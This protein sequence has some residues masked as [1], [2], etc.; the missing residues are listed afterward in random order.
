MS[1]GWSLGSPALG[2]HGRRDRSR[3]SAILASFQ[4]TWSRGSPNASVRPCRTPSVRVVD[5]PVQLALIGRFVVRRRRR[6][7]A[8]AGSGRPGSTAPR[9]RHGPPLPLAESALSVVDRRRA[10]YLQRSGQ[11]AAQHVG[12]LREQRLAPGVAQPGRAVGRRQGDVDHKIGDRNQHHAAQRR[13]RSTPGSGRSAVSALHCTKRAV[14]PVRMVKPISDT[15]N[16]PAPAIRSASSGVVTNFATIAV[17]IMEPVER[18]QRGADPGD[19]RQ[20][21]A[22]K[23]A[24]KREQRRQQDDGENARGRPGSRGDPDPLATQRRALWR[25]ARDEI[26]QTGRSRRSRARPRAACGRSARRHPGPGKAELR[27]FLEP[28][29]AVADR[30]D[31]ARQRRSRRRR[32]CRPA[33]ASR[34]APRAMPRRPPGRPPAR[35]CASRRRR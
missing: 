9:S 22:H 12:A 18:D 34:S 7:A 2:K 26:A 35:R 14:D 13:R 8:W 21:L 11:H 31:L 4:L 32:R 5:Q 15:K 17:D 20:G 30:A 3:A 23:A 6:P 19:D 24:G 10:L 27:R 29:L 28:R 25:Q 16:S 1:G 33:P